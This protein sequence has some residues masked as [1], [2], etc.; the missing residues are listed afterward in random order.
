M[1]YLDYFKSVLSWH[2][3]VAAG[4]TF[5]AAVAKPID[6][7]VLAAK[8]AVIQRFWQF[9]E[10]D[11]LPWLLQN[12]N[13]EPV[14]S[15]TPAQSRQQAADAW[16][17]WEGDGN[18]SIDGHK[19]G[20]GGTEEGILTELAR[21]GYKAAMI[22]V[23][24]ARYSSD[25][26]RETV[27]IQP[28]LRPDINKKFW[29]AGNPPWVFSTPGE[30]VGDWWVDINYHWSSYYIVLTDAPFAFRR[31]GDPGRWGE[32]FWDALVAGSRVNLQRIYSTARKF[33]PPEW[34][35]R[36]IVFAQ[37]GHYSLAPAV[38]AGMAVASTFDAW[39]VGAAGYAAHW[40]GYAWTASPTG[41]SADLAAVA[42]D[43]GRVYAVGAGGVILRQAG[44]W[45]LE[46]APT[47]ADLASL[48]FAGADI[49]AVGAGGVIL[50]KQGASWAAVTSPVATDLHC[51][52]ALGATDIWAVG[53][54]GVSLHWDGLS[55]ATVATG[56]TADLNG[57]WGAATNAVWAVGAG[58]VILKWNGT[59]WAAVSSPTTA[60]LNAVA[61]MKD[62]RAIATGADLIVYN[63]TSWA[64]IVPPIGQLAHAVAGTLEDNFWIPTAQGEVFNVKIDGTIYS[65]GRWDHFDWDDGTRYNLKYVIK[66]MREGWEL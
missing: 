11:A 49:W 13:L 61:G 6:D 64:A 58:G 60:D 54:G 53:A 25:G 44:G 5:Q 23:W 24:Q 48:C 50:R 8:T 42:M 20:G 65:G 57:L 10:D 51:V 59:S 28:T 52:F 17:T 45:H 38:L 32:G 4:E 66:T 37:S 56:T 62:G 55:W 2:Y 34:S 16:L 3:F 33:G 19:W 31:W 39:T 41:T 29:P 22:P 40:N 15:F 26:I 35:C 9:C 46:A 12:Y 7:L 27:T 30:F 47:T 36:G 14:E 18:P 1:T 43:A 63:G 21:L